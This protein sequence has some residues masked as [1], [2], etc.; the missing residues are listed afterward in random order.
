ML[1]ALDK[2]VQIRTKNIGTIKT[3]K[4]IFDRY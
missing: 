3:F 4:N 1:A 2:C